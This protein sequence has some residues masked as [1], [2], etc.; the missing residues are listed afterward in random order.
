MSTSLLTTVQVERNGATAVLR[1][2]RPEVRNAF[3]DVMIAEVDHAVR[4]L[5][6]DDTVRVIVVGAAGRAFC[7]GADL[8][9]M[10]RMASFSD[11]E[12]HADALRL[13]NML[14][15]LSTCPKPV[16][17]R[18]HGDCYAGGLG[19]AAACDIAIA[20]DIAGF[21][22]S[23]VKLGLIPATISPYVI[24]AMG[25]RAAGRYMV[26]GERFSANEALRVGLVHAVVAAEQLDSQIATLVSGLLANSPHAMQEA[27][28]LI[29][30]ISKR[31]I[32]AA[33]IEDTAHRIAS[34]RASLEG[35]EGV[36]AFLER[37][38][39]AWFKDS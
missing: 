23:E 14:A 6:R 31:P 26:T 10:R 8:N 21:C 3:D 17:A 38:R 20:A 39:P 9:W 13:A 29:R 22:L 28:R 7:A 19:L 4:E 27:K 25:E 18:I 15:A 24:A 5:G 11:A 33:L 34:M 16:I 2:N 1:L 37:R 12:N 30:D 35:R 32:D 36:G